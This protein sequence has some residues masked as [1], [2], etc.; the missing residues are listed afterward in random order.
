MKIVQLS[1]IISPKYLTNEHIKKGWN[2]LN[3]SEKKLVKKRIDKLFNDRKIINIKTNHVYY[4]HLFSFLAQVE[5][6]AIQIPLR[7]MDEFEGQIYNQLRNQLIDE[8]VHGIIFLKIAHEL[9]RPY[10]YPVRIIEPTEK[11]CDY[12]RCIQDKKLALICL[13]LIAEGWIEEIF[14][15]LIE[16]DVGNKYFK[17]IL[18]DE[19]RH[20]S[21]AEMYQ[22]IGMVDKGI[23]INNINQMEQHLLEA[24]SFPTISRSLYEVGGYTKYKKLVKGLFNKHKK[25][26]KILGIESSQIWNNFE[27]IMLKFY[28]N[29]YFD[30][31]SENIKQIELKNYQRMFLKVWKSPVDPTIYCNFSLNLNSLDNKELKHLT[32]IFLKVCAIYFKKNN[33]KHCK[34]LVNNHKLYQ[35][36]QVNIGVR[37]LVETSKGL[38]IGTI[39]LL[40]IEDMTPIAIKYEI[41]KGLFVLKYWKEKYINHLN[42]YSLKDEDKLKF[43]GNY[44][45]DIFKLPPIASYIPITLTNIGKFGYESGYSALTSF[46]SVDIN[47]G[48][49][50]KK[51]IFNE[52]IEKFVPMNTINVNLSVDHRIFDPIELNANQ[53][54]MEFEHYCSKKSM[55]EGIANYEPNSI[56]KDIGLIKQKLDKFNKNLINNFSIKSVGRFYRYLSDNTIDI[57]NINF[58][59]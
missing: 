9:A 30:D 31:E 3:K 7:F 20:V 18:D 19:V 48:K 22:R 4:I 42:T 56:Q 2:V 51:P 13:N 16:W 47:I 5:V 24:I 52:E 23:L 50:I 45:D 49:I 15:H 59:I 37:A 8:I 28:S 12:I 35:I 17:S 39:N 21:E 33:Y 25:Q 6:L 32:S 10:N 46:N 57:T 27:K 1:D 14:E 58:E 53:F 44:Y 43:N 41:M 40:N 55:H 34:T 29:F 54:K 11:F 26:V 36:N 38:E